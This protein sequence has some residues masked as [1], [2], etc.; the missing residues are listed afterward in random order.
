MIDASIRVYLAAALHKDMD[1]HRLSHIGPCPAKSLFRTTVYIRMN[2][3]F[4]I[5]DLLRECVST[6]RAKPTAPYL[7]DFSTSC[8]PVQ[9]GPSTRTAPRSGR[10]RAYL[11]GWKI[12]DPGLFPLHEIPPAEPLQSTG[13][14]SRTTSSLAIQAAQQG[15]YR[16]Q[17]LRKAE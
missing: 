13:L 8:S 10:S 12:V 4:S 17:A 9:F 3:E 5:N 15:R 6:Q 16:W 1:N 11:D 14:V 7:T 2:F